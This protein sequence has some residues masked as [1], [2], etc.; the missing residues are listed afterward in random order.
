MTN[1]I[2]PIKIYSG[3][4]I[5]CSIAHGLCPHAM[6][7][8]NHD[9]AGDFRSE[10]GLQPELI[11]M[12]ADLAMCESIVKSNDD[13]KYGSCLVMLNNEIV[14]SPPWDV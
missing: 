14:E 9:S 13:C 5:E 1:K 10:F 2:I 3:G 7:C 4:F 6:E 12:S 11:K 8:T